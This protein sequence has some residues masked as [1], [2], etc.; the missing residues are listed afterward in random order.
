VLTGSRSLQNKTIQHVYRIIIESP[1]NNQFS[2]ENNAKPLWGITLYARKYA[3][4]G[5]DVY[6]NEHEKLSKFTKILIKVKIMP[7]YRCSTFHSNNRVFSNK[8]N[9]YKW[10]YY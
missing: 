3:S 2:F 5:K 4:I 7:F 10:G 6:V 8:I 9:K 1:E